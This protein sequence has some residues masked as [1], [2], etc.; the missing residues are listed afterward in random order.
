MFWVQLRF[1]GGCVW[2]MLHLGEAA[3][4]EFALAGSCVGGKLR[5]GRNYVLEGVAIVILTFTKLRLS[6]RLNSLTLQGPTFTKPPSTRVTLTKIMLRTAIDCCLYRYCA[7]LKLYDLMRE[8][9]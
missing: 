3:F 4:E 7:A 9:L 5:Y 6:I 8:A 2:R 1:G